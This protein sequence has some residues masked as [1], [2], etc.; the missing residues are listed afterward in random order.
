LVKVD[1]IWTEM[2]HYAWFISFG[3]SFALYTVSMT[4]RGKAV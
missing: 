1:A 4:V 2:Y 3:V